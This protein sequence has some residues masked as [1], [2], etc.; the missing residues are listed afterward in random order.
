[1]QVAAMLEEVE[2]LP[3]PTLRVACGNAF[4]GARFETKTSFKIYVDMELFLV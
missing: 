2:V 3:A 4:A 1:M